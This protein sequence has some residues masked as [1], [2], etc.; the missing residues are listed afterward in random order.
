MGVF[1]LYNHNHNLSNS[2]LIDIQTFMRTLLLLLTPFLLFAQ[3][4]TTKGRVVDENQNPVSGAMVYLDGT[5]WGTTTDVNGNFSIRFERYI[6]PI[7]VVY[8]PDMRSVFINNPGADEE[9]V[10]RAKEPNQK[11]ISVLKEEERKRMIKL[12]RDQF[13]GISEAANQCVLLNEDAIE[14][15]QDKKNNI[16]FAQ[17]KERLL[18]S[19]E[20]LGY[21]ISFDLVEFYAVFQKKGFVKKDLVQSH[22]AGSSFY[23]LFD[24]QERKPFAKNRYRSYYGS[25]KH[26]FRNMI[27]KEWGFSEFMLYEANKKVD[28]REVLLIEPGE[29]IF[30]VTLVER[31]L[32]GKGSEIAAQSFKS[33]NVHYKDKMHSFLVFRTNTFEVDRFGNHSKQEYIEMGGEFTRKLFGNYLPLNYDIDAD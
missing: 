6:S 31:K 8:K 16:L 21:L 27:A 10:L 18:L 25:T 28:P 17:A 3:N 5:T 20:H 30:K 13:L 4:V 15:Y 24:D 29:D 2:I 22:F 9:V 11:P 1:S 33:Y 32:T 19:N 12:F 14:F 26:F 23:K 7:L